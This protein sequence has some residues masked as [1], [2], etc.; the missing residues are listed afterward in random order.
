MMLSAGIPIS[1]AMICA[2]VV[3]CPW[4]WLLVPIRAMPAPVGCIR[5]SQESNMAIP[6]MSQFFDGPA[7][8][9]SVKND[10]PRPM[11]SR[12]SPRLDA[13]RRLVGVDAVDREMCDRKVVRS[14]DD[15]EEAGRPFR[16]VGTGIER[17]VIGEHVDAQAGDLAFPGRRDFGC[18]VIIARERGRSEVFDAVLDPFDGFAGDDRGHRRANITGIGADLVAKTA[19]DIG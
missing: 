3:S 14:R 1:V 15:I 9:I 2:Q 8:T 7:P 11:I 18:H 4:P 10:T 5:I 17:T 19:T 13:A 6:R 16:R 12:V